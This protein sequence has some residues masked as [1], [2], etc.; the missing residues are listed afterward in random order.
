MEIVTK[1]TIRTRIIEG[2]RKK[3]CVTYPELLHDV[4]SAP[5]EM[6][7]T[8]RFH[9]DDVL[10]ELEHG[11]LITWVAGRITSLQP[12]AAAFGGGPE[13]A[14]LNRRGVFKKRRRA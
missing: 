5:A 2:L 1:K 3:P 9:F 10:R 14:S 4:L 8:S 13:N 6:D 12:E 7:N 11:G